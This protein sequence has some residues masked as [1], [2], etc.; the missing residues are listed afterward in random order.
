MPC[1]HRQVLGASAKVLIN[2][3]SHVPCWF[4]S[5]ASC[6][7]TGPPRAFEECEGTRGEAAKRRLGS[8]LMLHALPQLARL[9]FTGSHTSVRSSCK[10]E[11][12]EHWASN[13]SSERNRS[14]GARVVLVEREA[15]SVEHQAHLQSFC[16]PCSVKADL[17]ARLM[18]HSPTDFQSPS[19]PCN[20]MLKR[21]GSRSALA[22]ISVFFQGLDSRRI[23]F[24]CGGAPLLQVVQEQVHVRAFA[25]ARRQDHTCEKN[26]AEAAAV[27]WQSLHEDITAEILGM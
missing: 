6:S 4:A 21:K 8:V 2:A 7:K 16:P 17:W 20:Q 1:S 22:V 14:S 13:S 9:Q 10:D 27:S 18:V 3:F 15:R 25:A 26:S 12:N 5:S 11:A 24:F 23:V 19:A